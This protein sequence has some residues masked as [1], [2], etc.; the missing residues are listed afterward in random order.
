[1][2][3]RSRHWAENLDRPPSG[4][5]LSNRVTSLHHISSF[6]SLVSYPVFDLRPRPFSFLETLRCHAPFLFFVNTIMAVKPQN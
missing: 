3:I 5:F 1:M 4:L 6:S 2:Y